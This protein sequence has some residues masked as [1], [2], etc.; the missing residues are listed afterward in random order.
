MGEGYRKN[1]GMLQA[2]ARYL[3]I[4]SATAKFLLPGVLN[5]LRLATG[6]GEVASVLRFLSKAVIFHLKGSSNAQADE[7]VR[8][9]G[10]LEPLVNPLPVDLQ[11][12]ERL[13]G[14]EPKHR[15]CSCRKP[16]GLYLMSEPMLGSI[17]FSKLGGV[18]VFMPSS[19][20]RTAIA[21]SKNRCV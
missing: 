15:F 20:I 17:R 10:V 5:T 11:Q 21:V 8:L 12:V 14:A 4:F 9:Q 13:A 18:L 1:D 16:A 7:T 6:P 3:Q 19:R 2:Q